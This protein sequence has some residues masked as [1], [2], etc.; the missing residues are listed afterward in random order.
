VKCTSFEKDASGRVIEIRCAY[1]PLTRGGDAPDGRKVKGTL[2]WVSAEHSVSAEVRLYENLF[3][4]RDMDT[5]EQGK[6]YRDYLNPRSLETL[7]GCMLEP[8]LA[9]A[10]P[11]DRFQ[12]LRHGYFCADLEHSSDRPV[13]NRTVSLKDSWAKENR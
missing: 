2:Q 1:D 10:N 4:L 9:R 11:L 8:G 13:F 5:M 3:T 12:F 7:S 6:D